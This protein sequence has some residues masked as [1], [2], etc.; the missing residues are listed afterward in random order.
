MKLWICPIEKLNPLDDMIC[1]FRY[2]FVNEKKRFL[3]III[4]DVC[5]M[6]MGTYFHIQRDKPGEQN[7]A[8]HITNTVDVKGKGGR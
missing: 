3:I 5:V 7:I 2:Y 4:F 6:Y 8:N 1:N